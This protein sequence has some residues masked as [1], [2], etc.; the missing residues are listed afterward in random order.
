MQQHNV[1]Y[2]CFA[3]ETEFEGG[4]GDSDSESE[5]NCSNS[6]MQLY[7]FCAP[8]ENSFEA[9]I[10]ARRRAGRLGLGEAGKQKQQA[11]VS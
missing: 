10:R 4:R 8:I 11:P 2:I 9:R 1:V 5:T 7:K 3:R 6:T